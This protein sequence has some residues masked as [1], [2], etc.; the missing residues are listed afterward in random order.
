MAGLKP[1][2]K[3][4]A[5]AIREKTG[6]TAAIPASDFVSMVNNIDSKYSFRVSGDSYKQLNGTKGSYRISVFGDNA[7]VSGG[8]VFIPYT[9]RT[10]FSPYRSFNNTIKIE[11]K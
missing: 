2:L 11:L 1:L 7:Y 8:S 4:I 10:M 9:V 3:D 6:T 5:N